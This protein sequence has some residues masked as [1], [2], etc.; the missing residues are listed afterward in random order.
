MIFCV[1]FHHGVQE[2]MR[3]I[4][5]RIAH[6][7]DEVLVLNQVAVGARDARVLLDGARRDPAPAPAAGD[8]DAAAAR[9]PLERAVPPRPR[10]VQ[11]NPVGGEEQE[12]AARW[13]GQ[14]PKSEVSN[15]WRESGWGR[16]VYGTV[17]ETSTLAV[18]AELSQMLVAQVFLIHFNLHN[19]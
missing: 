6:L 13:L 12:G 2:M 11:G 8:G 10:P 14:N 18:P 4:L 9:Q 19:F 17:G 7:E 16:P 3:M 15:V 5:Q 1:C